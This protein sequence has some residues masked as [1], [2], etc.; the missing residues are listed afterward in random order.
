MALPSRISA[1][2]RDSFLRLQFT[3]E[4]SLYDRD[5]MIFLDETGSDR[6]NSIRKYG[7][8]IRGRPLVSEKLLVRGKRISA[9]AHRLYVSQWNA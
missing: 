7:Y 1:L 9:I 3:S 6:R 4:V 8:S 5:M 2:Q